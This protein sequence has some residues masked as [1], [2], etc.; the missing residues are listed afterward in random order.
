MALTRNEMVYN[1]IN[2]AADNMLGKAARESEIELQI[3]LSLLQNEQNLQNQYRQILIDNKLQLPDSAQ[4]AGSNIFLESSGNSNTMES[5]GKLAAHAKMNSDEMFQAIQDF[6]EGRALN[7]SLRIEG[8]ANIPGLP[9]HANRFSDPAAYTFQPE[10]LDILTSGPNP[11]LTPEQLANYNFMRGMNPSYE[12][13]MNFMQADIVSQKL[14][15]ELNELKY[16]T[17]ESAI[18]RSK[19]LLSQISTSLG[20]NL[21]KRLGS[22][23]NG[24]SLGM[25]DVNTGDAAADAKTRSNQLNNM[26]KQ[27]NTYGTIAPEVYAALEW[28]INPEDPSYGKHYGLA[29][30]GAAIYQDISKQQA[31]EFKAIS[32][33]I[34][35]GITETINGQDYLIDSE[36]EKLR[37]HSK[38]NDDG[39]YDII[40]DR[41]EQYQKLGLIF[42]ESSLE[43]FQTLIDQESVMNNKAIDLYEQTANVEFELAEGQIHPASSQLVWDQEINEARNIL[44]NHLH[45]GDGAVDNNDP[46]GLMIP[47]VTSQMTDIVTS[48]A[49]I[50]TAKT[51]YEIALTE[52]RNLLPLGTLPLPMGGFGMGEHIPSDEELQLLNT[53]IQNYVSNLTQPGAQTGTDMSWLL[54]GTGWYDAPYR[55]EAEAK[56]NI[57]GDAKTILQKWRKYMQQ[58]KKVKGSIDSLNAI[59]M[60]HLSSGDRF[61]GNFE[62][63]S[64]ASELGDILT[65]DMLDELF[66]QG[67][68]S[69]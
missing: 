66:E 50:E 33:G 44:N 19:A 38:Y 35:E 36:I 62:M 11:Q 47:E 6:N 17:S 5:L 56:A 12:E 4:T 29:K 20:I 41:V 51:D 16:T 37:D 69:E 59:K 60:G 61:E 63:L 27:I 43:K 31:Y 65:P 26:I 7:E 24:L 30:L 22:T 46:F 1:F 23:E 21:S 52:L 58:L 10:E 32:N 54:G 40:S 28:Y 67:E 57:E 8:K 49:Q 39:E 14:G 18:T 55:T 2:K 53:R 42:D 34:I 64:P 45:G 13:A 68:V 15:L 48:E 9:S 3:A 25:L